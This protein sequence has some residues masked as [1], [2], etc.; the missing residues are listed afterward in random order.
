MLMSIILTRR[1]E[2]CPLKLVYFPT[3]DTVGWLYGNC[4]LGLETRDNK[5]EALKLMNGRKKSYGARTITGNLC[6]TD[7]RENARHLSRPILRLLQQTSKSTWNEAIV[8][9]T[10]LIWERLYLSQN[11]ANSHSIHFYLEYFPNYNVEEVFCV[12]SFYDIFLA[13]NN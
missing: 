7:F 8:L 9:R 12:F 13:F 4:L 2:K 1:M 3:Y 10:R 11:P 5:I 6:T